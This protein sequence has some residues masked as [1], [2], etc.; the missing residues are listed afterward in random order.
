MIYLI[1]NTNQQLI[2][3]VYLCNCAMKLRIERNGFIPVSSWHDTPGNYAMTL[4]TKIGLKFP[5]LSSPYQQ[6]F[7]PYQ[8]I[9][10]M[11]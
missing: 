2:V 6:L 9:D 4:Y 7:W 10:D 8:Q 1:I 5:P 3:I 11:I